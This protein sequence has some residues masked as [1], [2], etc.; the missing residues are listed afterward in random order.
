MRHVNSP[1][2]TA[3]L[4][5]GLER[6]MLFAAPVSITGDTFMLS[7]HPGPIL[8]AGEYQ[9]LA[10]PISNYGFFDSTTAASVDG[11][12]NLVGTYSY[13][14]SGTTKTAQ[15]SLDSP[16]GH[17][18]ATLHFDHATSGTITVAFGSDTQPGF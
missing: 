7:F 8:S 17:V 16:F 14:R 13:A 12:S 9:F 4:I 6:R 15:L 18:G 5:T 2:S 10:S 11:F 1:S 3:I